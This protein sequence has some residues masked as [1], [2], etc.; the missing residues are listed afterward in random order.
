MVSKVVKRYPI[1]RIP[2]DLASFREALPIKSCITGI[3]T[4]KIVS[5]A[6]YEHDGMFHIEVYA[7]TRNVNTEE[8]APPVTKQIVILRDGNT[9][10]DDGVGWGHVQTIMCFPKGAYGGDCDAEPVHIYTRII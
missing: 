1:T 2:R 6:I 4:T 5:G 3:K 7:E 9:L 8:A 10:P